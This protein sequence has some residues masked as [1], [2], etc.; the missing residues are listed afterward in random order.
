MKD[1]GMGTLNP[2]RSD[3]NSL[4]AGKRHFFNRF[5][6][7]VKPHRF[8]HF[9]LAQLGFS[10]WRLLRIK[11]IEK[12]ERSG[13]QAFSSVPFQAGTEGKAGNGMFIF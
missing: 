1:P 10:P 6:E 12:S 13:E 8:Y 5:L 9:A 2:I 4:F 7:I 3:Y 11:R